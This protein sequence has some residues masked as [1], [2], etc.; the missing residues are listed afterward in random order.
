M[1][2]YSSGSSEEEVPYW[3]RAI[4]MQK[5]EIERVK[6]PLYSTGPVDGN[7]F[8]WEAVLFGPAG[9]PYENGV[10]KIGMH[11]PPEYPFKPPKEI[12]DISSLGCLLT[13]TSRPFTPSIRF[14]L[15]FMRC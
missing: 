2:S 10:F 7:M 1:P 6:S 5:K 13:T 15:N 14:S 3:E 4:T 12:V 8:Y 11:F 9:S